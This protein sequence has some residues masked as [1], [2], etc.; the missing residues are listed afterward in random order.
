MY[1]SVRLPRTEG[2]GNPGVD[3]FF[4]PYGILLEFIDGGSLFDHPDNMVS[5]VGVTDL[6]QRAVNGAYQI[7]ERGII[8]NDSGPRN[9]AVDKL[10][11]KPYII[12]LAQC[13]FKED[14]FKEE[15]LDDLEEGTTLEDAWLEMARSEANPTSIGCVMKRRLEIDHGI[16][17]EVAYPDMKKVLE[18]A[19]L[20]TTN[21]RR[22]RSYST[23]S[24][25][26]T[27]IN[28]G[29]GNDHR[30]TRGFGTVGT[31]IWLEVWKRVCLAVSGCRTTVARLFDWIRARWIL[32]LRKGIHSYQVYMY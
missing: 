30:G 11:N 5:P 21:P 16:K 7:N 29:L 1:A 25:P 27:M 6:V 28:R 15:D 32:S 31:Q 13:T 19:S 9:V 14:F 17:I 18:Y 24:G 2:C 4:S 3:Y 22:V 10:L 23:C 8:L 26:S 12:D 20:V